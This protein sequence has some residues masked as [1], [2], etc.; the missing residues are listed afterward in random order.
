M[1]VYIVHNFTD[2]RGRQ[3]WEYIAIFHKTGHPCKPAIF[4]VPRDGRFGEVSLYIY[5]MQLLCSVKSWSTY[6]K[7]FQ[8][9]HT[10][11]FKVL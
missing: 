9:P 8:H 10:A 11:K 1:Q 2:N 4:S 7:V 5:K 3:L 6:E